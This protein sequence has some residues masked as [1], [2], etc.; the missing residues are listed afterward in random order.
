MVTQRASK[1]TSLLEKEV[2]LN[3]CTFHPK[4]SRKS[5]EITGGPRVASGQ[6]IFNKNTEWVGQKEKLLE[7]IR[8]AMKDKDLEGCTFRPQVNVGM[9]LTQSKVESLSKGSENE[10]F[11]HLNMI[12][13][14]KFLK[15]YNKAH[16]SKNSEANPTQSLTAL[17][18]SRQTSYLR[19]VQEQNTRSDCSEAIRV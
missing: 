5:I 6:E 14:Q 18:N 10:N 8:D 11:D 13:I 3:E 19:S 15:R 2:E 4:I 1:A 7:N 16:N 17:K 12:S 9:S